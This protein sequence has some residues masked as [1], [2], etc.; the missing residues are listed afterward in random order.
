MQLD[1][2]GYIAAHTQYSDRLRRPCCAAAY[3]PLLKPPMP[4]IPPPGCVAAAAALPA[5]MSWFA[6]RDRSSGGDPGGA[7]AAADCQQD[8]AD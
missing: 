1:G 8:A 2:F 3:T 6:P 7:R 5:I 4:P